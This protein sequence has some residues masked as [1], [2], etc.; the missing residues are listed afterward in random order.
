M[1]NLRVRRFNA[2]TDTLKP[3]DCGNADLNGFLVESDPSVPNATQYEAEL[4][5]VTYVLED[6]DS[7]AVLAYFSLLNDKIDRDISD[8]NVWNHLSRIIPNAKRRRS[9]PAVK[10]GRLAVSSL[11]KSKGL[12]TFILYFIKEW[13]LERSQTGCRFITVDALKEALPFYQKN[14]FVILENR[15]ANDSDTILMYFDLM[16]LKRA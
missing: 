15:R 1:N 12:G 2:G 14:H 10:I 5:A 8:R 7:N 3:F 9:Y 4:M 16:T 6:R 13:F 11:M